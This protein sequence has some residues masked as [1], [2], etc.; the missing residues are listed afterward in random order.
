MI[1]ALFLMNCLYEASGE[2]L[3]GQIEVQRTVL[4]R[5]A[6]SRWPATIEEVITQPYQ[7]SWLNDFKP[8]D[9]SDK[10]LTSCI[11]ATKIAIELGPSSH[12]HYWACDGLNKIDLPRWAVGIKPKK[13][14]NHCFG[15]L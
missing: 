5:V 7:F 8:K 4:S 15:V 1:F 6:D 12:N 9:F 11:M 13:I 2:P 3:K 10:A 14:G